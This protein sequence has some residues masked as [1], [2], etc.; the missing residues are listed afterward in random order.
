LRHFGLG[1]SSIL[2]IIDQISKVVLTKTL[3]INKIIILDSIPDVAPIL[4]VNIVDDAVV[5]DVHHTGQE[6]I[7][8]LQLFM[9]YQLLG[10]LME[11]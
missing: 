3:I 10:I 5:L 9:H 11:N 2:I 4:I 7:R 6:A 1:L 8:R